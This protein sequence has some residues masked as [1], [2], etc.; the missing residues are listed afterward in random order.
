MKLTPD[1]NFN[2]TVRK[3]SSMVK[4]GNP[5]AGLIMIIMTKKSFVLSANSR[6]GRKLSD[7]CP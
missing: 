7:L 3:T 1:Y 2:T 6:S 5:K 4:S